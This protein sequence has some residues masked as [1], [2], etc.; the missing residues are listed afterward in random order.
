MNKIKEFWNSLPK[1][2]RNGLIS[3]LRNAVIGF[4][5][6]VLA[7]LVDLVPSLELSETATLIIIGVLK[8]LDETLHKTGIAEKG[9][10]RF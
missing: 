7:G 9:I 6:V 1:K 3:L 4:A 10:T 5:G 8:L 2:F